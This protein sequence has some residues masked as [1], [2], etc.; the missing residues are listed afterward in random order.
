MGK[1]IDLRGQV[2]G[3]LVVLCENGRARSGKVL[4]RCRC[5]CGNEVIVRS[6]VL[7]SGCSKSCG[8]YSRERAAEC[9]TKHGLS[10]SRLYNIWCG[11]LQRTGVYEGANEKLKRYYID[12]GITV[13]S[14]WKTF[15]CFKQWSLTHGYSD[16]LQIDRIDNNRGYC[17][18]NCRWVTPK[19]NINNRKCTLR[20]ADGTAFADFCRI[21]GIETCSNNRVTKQYAKYKS[22][23]KNHNGEAHPEL[24]KKANDIISLYRK[25]LR[26]LELLDDVR[27]FREQLQA[28][29]LSN[30]RE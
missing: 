24:L 8:C 3:R 25:C 2:F 30:S 26:M 4:W 22:W 9:S 18:E 29:L 14:E 16:V 21:F 15:A 13:C 17:P 5:D 20:M 6:D 19:E 28:S 27:A 7:R 10:K 12:R 23:F 1:K 11:M